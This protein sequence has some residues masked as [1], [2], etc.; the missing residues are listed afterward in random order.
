MRELRVPS[1]PNGHQAYAH[2]KGLKGEL[3]RQPLRVPPRGYRDATSFNPERLQRERV[4]PTTTTTPIHLIHLP[5]PPTASGING[6]GS[7]GGGTDRSGTDASG[8]GTTLLSGG[9]NCS[10]TAYASVLTVSR[11]GNTFISKQGTAGRGAA[12]ANASSATQLQWALL[13]TLAASL[14]RHERCVRDFILLLGN[15]VLVPFGVRESL[16]ELGVVTVRISPLDPAIPPLDHLHAWRLVAYKRVVVLDSDMLAI[17]G[18]DGLFDS[19]R[20]YPQN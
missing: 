8:N 16:G 3:V 9:L 1:R 20:L 2:A 14:R 11:W 4:W 15:D 17:R 13:L 6:S 10:E 19:T 12:A 7:G 18:I 5:R